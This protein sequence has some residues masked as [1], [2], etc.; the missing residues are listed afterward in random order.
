ML[1]LV[2]IL[3]KT[4]AAGE[5]RKEDM[6]VWKRLDKTPDPI[7]W[8][9]SCDAKELSTFPCALIWEMRD[10]EVK[11]F[12]ILNFCS[13]IQDVSNIDTRRVREV[14]QGSAVFLRY[15]EKNLIL[16][17]THIIFYAGVTTES[18]SNRDISIFKA[19]RY[20]DESPVRLEPDMTITSKELDGKG[21]TVYG[22]IENLPV[23]IRGT[24]VY[25][26]TE[27]SEE[28]F[29]LR[30]TG[31]QEPKSYLKKRFIMK[32]PRG[33][34][35][36]LSGAPVVYKNKVVGVVSSRAKGFIIFN[37]PEDIQ[38]VLQQVH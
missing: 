20:T 4:A 18:L 26:E 28:G 24:A 22:I 15:R 5:Q 3:I 21:V 11:V 9:V 25:T 17:S 34:W 13:Q 8:A 14:N 19:N 33:D 27:L 35:H 29:S 38:A 1:L 32:M 10:G 31:V 37:P 30:V 6:D 2:F 12:S 7:L 36:G 23:E 16:T